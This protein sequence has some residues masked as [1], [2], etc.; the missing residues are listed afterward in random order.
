MS[1]GLVSYRAA[2]I[3]SGGGGGVTP[4]NLLA[5]QF[6]GVTALFSTAKE[7][8]TYAG[9]AIK[10]SRSDGTSATDI[11]FSGNDLNSSV[12]DTYLAG[13]SA[14]IDIYYNQMGGPNALQ[15]TLARR[16]QLIKKADG[17]YV[18]VGKTTVCGYVV[19]DDASFKT[20]IVDCYFVGTIGQSFNEGENEFAPIVGWTTTNTTD[21]SATARWGLSFLPAD[22]CLQRNA[23]G[24]LRESG[25]IPSTAPPGNGYRTARNVWHY[26][27][28]RM[29]LRRNDNLLWDDVTDGGNTTANVTYSGTGALY[30]GME[31]ALN[32]WSRGEFHTLA[33]FATSRTDHASIASYLITRNNVSEF[34]TV[35]NSG[36]GFLWSPLYNTCYSFDPADDINGLRYWYETGAYPDNGSRGPSM[37]VASNLTNASVATLMRF[38]VDSSDSDTIVNGQMR[39]ERGIVLGSAHTTISRGDTFERFCQ[40]YIE[41][42]PTMVPVSGNWCLGFQTHYDSDTPAPDMFFLDFSNDE[43]QGV[44]QKSTSASDATDTPQGS[45]VP[46]TR[47]TWY[48]VRLRA[49]WS[50][51]G[52]SDILQV[53]IGPNGGTLTLVVNITSGA[54][55]DTR[56]TGPANGKQGVYRGDNYNSPPW[57]PG[58]FA[59][60]VANEK[61]SKTDGAF[62]SFVATQP[63][64][65]TTT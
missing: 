54:V 24:G 41:A 15:T 31:P 33:L 46:Y 6:S 60:R 7:N 50:A 57:A 20:A 61:F 19:A 35:Y 12:A 49:K 27:T 25:S 17:K 8:S 63:A 62:A 1:F 44:S 18:G 39:C 48:A 14:F 30:I 36:D 5:D 53:W 51:N 64:L 29:A 4:T 26:N 47:N 38:A 55:F 59:I 45:P 22:L 42:G 58:V 52:L 9:N 40:I 56:T 13:G 10:V 3:S 65:P 23:A 2:G 16:H 32:N 37:A 21:I 43:F 11:G 28:E 34:P